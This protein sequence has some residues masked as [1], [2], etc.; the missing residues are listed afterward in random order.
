MRNSESV[1]RVTW[2]DGQLTSFS[3]ACAEGRHDEPV[4]AGARFDGRYLG[5]ASPKT[6]KTFW[7]FNQFK[8]SNGFLDL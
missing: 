4:R 2:P 5:A 8:T 6:Q 3:F 1:L 7:T